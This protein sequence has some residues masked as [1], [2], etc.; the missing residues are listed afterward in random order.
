[1][2]GV[3]D[4]Y[5]HSGESILLIGSQIQG[6]VVIDQLSVLKHPGK[7]VFRRGCSREGKRRVT[8]H[9][10][11]GQGRGNVVGEK[12][13]RKTGSVKQDFWRGEGST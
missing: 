4:Q 5:K 10:G 9:M 13:K 11:Q 2:G 1:M 8:T 3:G 6:T 7:G 12:S